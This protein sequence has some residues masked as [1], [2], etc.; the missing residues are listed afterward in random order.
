[1]GNQSLPMY[2][3]ARLDISGGDLGQKCR[4]WRTIPVPKCQ[5]AAGPP[6]SRLLRRSRLGEFCFG[7]SNQTVMPETIQFA[8]T[9]NWQCDTRLSCRLALNETQCLQSRFDNQNQCR[10]YSE[11]VEAVKVLPYDET[12]QHQEE[13]DG[14][15]TAA[16]PSLPTSTDP[17]QLTTCLDNNNSW[18]FWN[19]TGWITNRCMKNTACQ[20]Y[21]HSE[22]I[23]QCV[24]D[25]EL[26][27]SR[28]PIDTATL[29]GFK[30]LYDS[31][32]EF[33]IIFEISTVREFDKWQMKLGRSIARYYIRN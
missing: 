7:S 16:L 29:L 12:I 18:A 13:D 21:D 20:R 17:L 8:D 23:S 9:V 14:D 6:A 19:G 28:H 1:M 2:S 33:I 15:E 31:G 4:P 25:K 30:V 32:N 3:C 11:P 10:D 26:G 5:K 24:I 22:E 27:Q